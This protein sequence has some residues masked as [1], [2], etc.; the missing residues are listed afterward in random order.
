MLTEGL[1]ECPRCGAPLGNSAE[2]GQPDRSEVF[3]LS[4]YT[5]GIAL[6]PILIGVAIGLIC[7]LLFLSGSN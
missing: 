5:V 1:A 4:T 3:W 7:I 2:N 6:I